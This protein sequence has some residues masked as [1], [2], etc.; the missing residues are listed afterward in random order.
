M[1][2]ARKIHKT[3]KQF[4]DSISDTQ[5]DNFNILK[6]DVV[7]VSGN[8]IKLTLNQMFGN[9]EII[10]S[11]S[12]EEI[13]G[14]WNNFKTVYRQSFIRM[15]DALTAEYA[16]TE[17]YSKVS[18]ITTVGNASTSS[19]SNVTNKETTEDSAVFHDTTFS[20]SDNTVN[21]NSSNTVTE[22][23]HGN[24]GVKSNMDFITE[25]VTGRRE[26][27][28]AKIICELYAETELI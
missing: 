22:N 23:T 20:D 26:M 12:N 2:I 7:I 13:I 15:Y 24:I 16:P 27:A 17:N 19:N 6:N 5:L 3:V 14:Y 28:L 8:T 18:T 1:Y 25:E 9:F 4:F 11:D 21:A 10:H